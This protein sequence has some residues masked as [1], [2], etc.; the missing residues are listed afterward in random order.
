MRPVYFSVILSPCYGLS[1]CNY[2]LIPRAAHP[3]PPSFLTVHYP[4]LVTAFQRNFSSLS[5]LFVPP[6][7]PSLFAGIIF[8]PSSFFFFPLRTL[9]Q[10]SRRLLWM[11]IHPPLR[12]SLSLSFSLLAS[13]DWLD[14]G[15]PTCLLLHAAILFPVLGTRPICFALQIELQFNVNRKLPPWL[16]YSSLSF[17][18]FTETRFAFPLFHWPLHWLPLRHPHLI[19]G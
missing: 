3:R 19:T 10:G 9:G 12:L 16:A 7:L 1:S 11:L 14:H 6:I 15:S 8:L 18:L 17:S 2:I 5:P 4:S 13:I